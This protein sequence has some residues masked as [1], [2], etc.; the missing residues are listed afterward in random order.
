ME[1]SKPFYLRVP[2]WAW[3]AVVLLLVLGVPRL[4]KQGNHSKLIEAANESCRLWN[5]GKA[6][7]Q[8][9]AIMAG[10]INSGVDI[11]GKT[12]GTGA[13]VA[14]YGQILHRCGFNMQ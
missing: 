11:H 2:G 1:N 10:L 9:E 4:L 14:E 13:S 5:S 12:N 8:K 7:T 3:S 6:G